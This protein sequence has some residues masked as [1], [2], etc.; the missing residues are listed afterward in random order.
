MRP[1]IFY[2][3]TADFNNTGEVLIYRTLLENLR[4][5]G[6][7]IIDD[8]A[9]IQPLFLQRIGIQQEERLHNYTSN[10][11]VIYI[12]KQSIRNIFRTRKFYFVTGVGD[13]NVSGAKK[14]LF[15]FVF[16]MLCKLLGGMKVLRIGMSISFK[17]KKASISEKILSTLISYYYVRDTI[18]L[19]SCKNIGINKVQLAPD[20]SWGYIVKGVDTPNSTSN[21]IILSFRDYCTNKK[22]DKP[23]KEILTKA[24]E[25]IIWDICKNSRMT[26]LFTYQ[27]DRDKKYMQE[28]KKHFKDINNIN[29]SSE[30]ITLDNASE[31]YGKARLIITNR[32]HVLLLAYKYGA[33]TIG[34]TDLQKHKKINGIF[35]DNG[36]EDCLLDIYSNQTLLPIYNKINRNCTEYWYKIHEVERN[37]GLKLASIFDKVFRNGK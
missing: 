27:C 21:C 3:T 33:L 17:D 23:Y 37:N 2:K 13:H 36:L 26:I 31:Y 1:I 12:L 14:N 5:Y 11:F 7:V 18:S 4:K 32:L 35:I 29:L 16:L 25:T 6:N 20:L 34:L 10:S 30:L 19:N 28:L 24:I 15:S 8:S 9:H 22:N